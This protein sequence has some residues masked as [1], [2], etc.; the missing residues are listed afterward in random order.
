MI[1]WLAITV[2]AEASTISGISARP[3]PQ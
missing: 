1:D 2:A 3:A